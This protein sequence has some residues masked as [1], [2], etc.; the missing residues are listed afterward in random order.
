MKRDVRAVGGFTL[1]EVM[2]AVAVVAILSAIAISQ[3]SQYVVRS[4]LVEAQT[5]LSALATNLQQYYQDNRT[6]VG[7][8]AA[9]GLAALPAAT[10]NFTYACPTKTA[11]AFSISATG[12]TGT[13]VAGFTFTLDQSGNRATSTVPTGWTASNSCWVR[14]QSGSCN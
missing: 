14:N 10:A 1:I 8:C 5:Q 3:Y 2:V 4:R 11:T 12:N 13:S 6:F 7:A 9:S